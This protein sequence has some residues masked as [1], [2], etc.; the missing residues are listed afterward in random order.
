MKKTEK[1]FD[2]VKMMRDIRAKLHKKYKG[3]PEL[4]Q[5]ELE[6]IRKQYG[7]EQKTNAHSHA[8]T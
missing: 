2:A 5:A 4:R 1:Q 3:H 6:K 7:F 8:N